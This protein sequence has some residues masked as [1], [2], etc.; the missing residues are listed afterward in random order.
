MKSW[1]E[2]LNTREHLLLSAVILVVALVLLDSLILDQ[3]R[4]RNQQLDDMLVQAREDLT[5][6]KQAVQRLPAQGAAP[7]K[8]IAA[9]RVAS[10]IDQQISRQGLK[11][12]MLQMTPVQDHSVRLRLQE[13]KFDQLL[14]FFASIEDQVFITEVRILPADNPGFVNASLMVSNGGSVS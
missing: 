8:R 11:D 13:V 7:V 9:G 6:M 10:F 14:N 4:Q 2:S 5:W 3:Y 1:W 12:K